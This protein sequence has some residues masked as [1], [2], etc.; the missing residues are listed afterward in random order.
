M[1][2]P[3]SGQRVQVVGPGSGEVRPEWWVQGLVK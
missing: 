2:G 3:G 1:V